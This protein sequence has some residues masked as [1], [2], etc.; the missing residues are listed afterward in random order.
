MVRPTINSVKHIVQ[1]VKQD[2]GGAG[3]INNNV[4]VDVVELSAINLQQEVREGCVIKAIYLEFWA[5]SDSSTVALDAN[6]TLEKK[7]AGVAVMSYANSI[8]LDDY[9]N[10]KNLLQT[11][12]GLLPVSITNPIPVFKGWYKIPKGKQRFG[13][14]DRLMFNIAGVSTGVIYCGFAIYK[15]YY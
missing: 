3:S 13:L 9:P 5:S 11:F 2:T 6:A 14:G 4:L 1:F 10:K 12:V 7:P 8:T 15:E